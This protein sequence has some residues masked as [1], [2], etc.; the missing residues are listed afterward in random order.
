[1]KIIFVFAH[2]DDETFSSGGTIHKLTELGHKVELITATKG[3]V[4]E[5]GEPPVTTKEKLGITREKELKEAAKIL[6]ISKVFFLGFIDGTLHKLKNK[7]L[8]NAIL[9]I[10]EKEIPDIVVTFDKHGGSNHPDHKAISKAATNAYYEYAG[11][12]SK[13]VK[14]YHTATPKSYLKKYE[15]TGLTYTAFGKQVGLKDHLI[16]TRIKIDF[17]IKD[18]ASRKHKSQHKDWE[19]FL[20]RKEIVSL[21]IEFFNLIHETWML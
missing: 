7:E 14:L 17:K 18:K 4:G 16:T 11:K 10:L 12:Q 20:K 19:R 9:P 6:G 3:E 21:D 2:P 8:E 5:V 1:M 15:E 13:R